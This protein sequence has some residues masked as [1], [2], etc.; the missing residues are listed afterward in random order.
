MTDQIETELICFICSGTLET[1]GES[2]PGV[3]VCAACGTAA[4][5]AE[6]VPKLDD[7]QRARCRRAVQGVADTL[8][9][10]ADRYFQGAI[11]DVATWTR[12][13]PP[14]TAK[15]WEPPPA[16][17]LIPPE[18]HRT[19]GVLNVPSVGALGPVRLHKGPVPDRF[20]TGGFLNDLSAFDAADFDAVHAATAR[21]MGATAT[22]PRCMVTKIV[23]PAEEI[24]CARPPHG[25]QDHDFRREI[26][27]R[28]SKRPWF[29]TIT[30][31]QF[32][33]DDPEAYQF[34][35]Y[36]TAIALA[37]LCRFAGQLMRF[38]SVAQHSIYVAFEVARRTGNARL[39]RAAQLHDAAEQV[40]VDLPRPL[41]NMPE[42]AWYRD[43]EDRVQRHIL[44]CFG[45]EEF[46]GHPEIKRADRLALHSEKRALRPP[47]PWE[48]VDER[49][50]GELWEVVP[51]A[52][53]IVTA[54]FLDTWKVFGGEVAK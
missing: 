10:C 19:D 26:Q 1:K 54:K 47:N 34:S 42:M 24:R 20:L 51:E 48:R 53:E 16:P 49:V 37:N 45:L 44:R 30:G 21:V 6:R 32:F 5:G 7:L 33:Y 40:M 23:G 14:A 22:G 46:F 39:A 11:S 38:Y 15:D 3:F 28:A 2:A 8:A 13:R 25:D 50:A 17:A 36:E 35:I 18:H 27:T 4:A 9:N 41:K 43:R 31:R 29:L 12:D 52:P